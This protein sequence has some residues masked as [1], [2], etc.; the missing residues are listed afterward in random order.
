MQIAQTDGGEEVTR[1]A[2]TPDGLRAYVV[3]INPGGGISVVDTSTLIATKIETADAYDDIV[4]RSDGKFAYAANAGMPGFISIVDTQTNSVNVLLGTS[5]NFTPV[6][7]VLSHDET[8]L[9][10][11]GINQNILGTELWVVDVTNGSVLQTA[12][13]PSVDND[14]QIAITPDGQF[15]YVTGG[16]SNNVYQINTTTLAFNVVSIGVFPLF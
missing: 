15:V 6:G 12:P 16:A 3:V 9:F 5:E 2:F 7:L 13:I 4:V 11:P 10:V 8:K 14:S 1:M